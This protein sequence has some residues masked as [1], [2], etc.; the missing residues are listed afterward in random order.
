MGS[1]LFD[2]FSSKNKEQ[3]QGKKAFFA[4]MRILEGQWMNFAGE[5]DR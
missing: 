4:G 3:V 1:I 5:R 2:Y